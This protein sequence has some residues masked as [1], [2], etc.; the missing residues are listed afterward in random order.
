MNGVCC[1]LW[2]FVLC[3]AVLCLCGC[4]G[5]ASTVDENF[6][7]GDR[8]FILAAQYVRSGLYDDAIKCLNAVI[9]AHE[10]APE[11]S[12]LL[13]TIYLDKKNDPICAIYFLRKYLDVC[14]IDK[15]KTIAEQLIVTAK[16]EFLKSLPAYNGIDQ[17]EAE[18]MEILKAMKDQNSALRS[19]IALCRQKIADYE[20][21]IDAMSRVDEM[22]S[23][24][25]GSRFNGIAVTST[26]VVGPGETLSSIS[27]KYYGNPNLWQKIF[28]ANK[29]LLTTPESLRAGQEL[30]I[31]RP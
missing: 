4:G 25:A 19:Q 2:Y 11:S 9:G 22:N 28:E 10:T 27:S 6:E 8:N 21:K 14:G 24:A 7:I 5:S 20:A 12:L 29:S 23:H 17:S 13:G 26:H 31:P 18:L 16:K 1:V 30:V 3:P 15:S